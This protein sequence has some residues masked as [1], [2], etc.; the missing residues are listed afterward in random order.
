MRQSDTGATIAAAIVLVVGMGFGRFAFTGLY[1]LMVA[2]LQISVEG[3]SYAA[4]ANYAGY[5]IGALLAAALSG[6]PSRKLCTF[7][8]ITT[9]ITVGLLAL[10]LPVWLIV[11]LRGF[12]G[13]CSAVSM[14]AASQWLIQD[15]RLHGGAAALYSGVG[16]GILVSAEMIAFGHV[17]SLTSHIIWF[18]LAAA[19]LIL[20]IICVAMQA[21]AERSKPHQIQD[22]AA[23][24]DDGPLLLGATRLVVIYGLAGLGYIITATYLPL[25]VRSAFASVDPVHIWALFGL[26]AVPSCF[27]WHSLHQKWGT[28]RSLMA[29]LAVQALG[30]ILPVFHTPVSYIVS[31]LLVGGTFMGTVT[32]AMPAAR[33]VAAK[34]RF[35]MLGIMTASYG[36]GQIIGPLMANAVYSRTASFD[37]SLVI[38]A[39]ALLMAATLC[40]SRVPRAG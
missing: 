28:H 17:A 29:N 30:V 18:A 5:L 21:Q 12:S 1:P 7:A 8:T 34:V 2:D 32:I 14:V 39:M 3:G 38:A 25:L 19:A 6:I 24:D 10:P 36:V 4:S 13:L 23:P 26:G 37:V 16:I 11:T 27:L 22:Q 35:N 20:A 33:K 9:V 40:F 31:A 15:R